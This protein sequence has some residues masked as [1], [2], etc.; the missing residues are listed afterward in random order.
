MESNQ[1]VVKEELKNDLVFTRYLYS[2]IH[3]KQSLLLSLLDH[4]YNECL[5]WVYELYFSGFQDECY[6]YIFMIYDMIYK[7]TNLK[8]IVFLEKTFKEWDEEPEKHW[9]IGTIVGTLCFCD[10]NLEDFVLSYFQ[11][12]SHQIPLEEKK[13]TFIIRLKEE[14]M[15]QFID[16]PNTDLSRKYLKSA[17]HF[18]LRTETNRLFK[19]CLDGLRYHFHNNW[20][21]YASYSPVWMERIKEFQ[22][23]VDEDSIKVFFENEDFEEEFYNKWGL[24]PDEQ[25][26]EL[27]NMILG[28]NVEQIYVK[29][30]CEKYRCIIPTKKIKIREPTVHQP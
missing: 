10:Y 8:F 28:D 27:Q 1:E 24:E 3:V 25:T 6:E 29:D 19:G 20:L 18:P 26:S 5:F 21:F 15:V 7:K 16:K 17:C 2:K 30:F 14:D 9:L 4:N 13:K 11:I 12:T 22:G 23:W